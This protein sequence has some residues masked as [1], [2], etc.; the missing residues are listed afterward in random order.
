MAKKRAGL[1]FQVDF[2][3]RLA[4]N[5]QQ[6][7][8]TDT[9]QHIYQTNHWGGQKSVSGD[10]ADLDQIAGI[11]EQLPALFRKLRIARLLDLPCG[12]FHW[13]QTLDL[14]V[15]YIGGDIIP[16]L[17]SAH[18]ANFGNDR[19]NF[20]LLDL[21]KDDLPSAD[22][23]LCRDCLVHLS[24]E[25]IF[26]AIRNLSRNPVTYLLTT[27]FSECEQN[28]DIVTGDWRILNLEK[29]PFNFPPPLLLM[30]EGCTEGRGTYA[31]KCLGL[32]KI[33]DLPTQT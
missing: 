21:T 6:K 9:F 14:D 32:W 33:S 4:E 10:G 16:E 12:D 29:P 28:K 11:K 13:M 18:Q 27:T 23:I 26:R 3:R 25:D 15:D 20:R 31:D 22:L 1:P 8:L 19:R 24:F 7:S 30:N 17:I 5:G 2:F